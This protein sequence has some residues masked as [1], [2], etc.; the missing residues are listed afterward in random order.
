M[1][2]I[3][4]KILESDL[5]VL[6]TL[7][8][9]EGSA[10]SHLGA[11][12]LVNESGLV[13]G[14][15]GGG[16]IENFAIIKATELIKSKTPF[17]FGSWNLQTDIKMSCG[18]KVALSFQLISSE[19]LN[20][21]GVF[22]AGHVSQELVPLLLKAGYKVLVHDERVEWTNKFQKN[23]N[24]KIFNDSQ[25]ENIFSELKEDACII[26]ITKG[27]DS[28]LPVLKQALLKN[29]KYVGVMGSDV[30]AKKIKSQLLE[31][32]FSKEKVEKV[33]SPIG[34]DIK[35]NQPFHIAISIISEILLLKE[36]N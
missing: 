2:K 14:T 35:S 22:G 5:V 20:T 18:G 24:L 3:F 12:M 4:K 25:L 7:V 31:F 9:I 10:P 17:Y 15:I 29:Y 30:K 33:K 34:I 21:V 27:H 13:E 36:A 8:E 19:A 6:V 26:S 11:Q 1:N 16:K 23:T 28:D 32:G